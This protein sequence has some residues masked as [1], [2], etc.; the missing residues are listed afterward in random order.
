MLEID[1]SNHFSSY[2]R[3]NVIE[4]NKIPLNTINDVYEIQTQNQ[5]YIAKFMKRK[6]LDSWEKERFIRTKLITE[7]CGL[8]GI[9]VPQCLHASGHSFKHYFGYIY[10]IKSSGKLLS[11]LWP[12]LSYEQRNNVAINLGKLVKAIHSITIYEINFMREKTFPLENYHR[13]QILFNL[14]I[15]KTRLQ[16]SNYLNIDL[17]KESYDFIIKHQKF[18]FITPVLIHTDLSAENILIN[19]ETLEISCI[20]D[21]EW[22]KL[23]DPV[24]DLTSLEELFS[25]NK[26]AKKTFLKAYGKDEIE[27]FNLKKRIYTI[28]QQLETTGIGY[29]FHNPYPEAV[30][31]IENIIKKNLDST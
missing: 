8:K 13:N 27:D 5:T 3:E 18:L 7:Y 10:M 1:I 15:I 17:V 29:Y 23:S 11:D 31:R 19:H 28:Y 26:E 30:P 2:I 12:K 4:I 6:P 14:D 24:Y 16:K 22:A 20:F 25:D 21:W 9:P